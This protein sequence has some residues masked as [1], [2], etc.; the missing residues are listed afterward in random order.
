MAQDPL[1][2]ALFTL[3]EIPKTG[4]FK[5]VEALVERR[6][7]VV[8][9][10]A[11]ADAELAKAQA[12]CDRKRAPADQELARLDAR[13]GEVLLRKR[14]VF[15][16]RYGK[17]INLSGGTVRYRLDSKSLDTPKNVTAIINTLL[18]LRGGKKYLVMKW[19]LNRDALTQASESL[20]GKLRPLG[21]R[22]RRHEFITIKSVGE[23][24]PTTLVRRVYRDRV[25]K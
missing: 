2:P 1:Q 8:A 16:N 17:V 23:D 12:T 19:S 5:E 20:L 4:D 7:E 24:E 3:H 9:I 22:V 6:A 13:L 18:L 14:R 21:V 15:M 11:E 25:S 10:R